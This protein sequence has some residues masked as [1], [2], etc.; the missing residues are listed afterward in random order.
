VSFLTPD[1]RHLD[2]LGTDR[3]AADL[4]GLAGQARFSRWD[5]RQAVP[6]LS[7]DE[8][9]DALAE[10]MLEHGDLGEALRDLM[11]RGWQSDDPSRG[12]LSG[13]RDLLDRLR[14]QR[15]SIRREGSL[16]DPLGDVRQA[17]EEIVSIER[18]GLERRLDEAVGDDAS[19]GAAMAEP[20]TDDAD[21]PT[22]DGSAA[23]PA[24]PA[25]RPT[26]SP[27]DAPES[28]ARLRRMLREIAARRM[29]QLDAMPP[30]VG[31][32]IRTL[33]DYDFL[34]PEARERFDALLDQL[35]QSVLDRMSEGLADAVK[36]MRPEDLAAQ[37][38]MVRDLN[39]LLE[40]R[41]AGEEPSQA[42]VDEFLRRHGG[43]FPGAETLDDVVEQLADRM[44]ALQSLL[45]SLSPEQRSEL[46]DTMDAL[47]RDDRLRWDLAQLAGNLDRLLPGGL[48]ERMQLTGEPPLGLEGALDQLG[49]LQALDA[50]EAS[51]EQL[52]DPGALADIDRSELRDLLGTDAVR[53]LDALESLARQLEQAGYLERRGERLELTPRGSRRIGQK[54]LDD[55]FGRLRRDAFGGHRIDRPGRGG[56]R[57]EVSK[58]YEHG[59]PFHL[60]LR[61][62]LD[63][64]LRR[65]ENAPNRRQG[66]VRLRPEDFEVHRTERLT[67]AAT[68]L[69]VDMSRSMLLRG[70]YIAAKR[71]AIALET[72]IRTQ[73]PRDHLA[74][75]GFAYYARELRPQALPELTWHGYEYGTNLQHGLLLARQIL[76]RQRVANREIVV[77][78]DG[79]PTAHF[80]DGQVEFSYPPT[81]RTV[82]ETLREVIRCTKEG[83]TINTFMLERSRALTDFVGLVTQLNRGRAFYAEPERLGEY[84]LVDFVSRRTGRSP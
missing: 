5:G 20:A 56:E 17:L 67:S 42:D 4:S 48:G 46:Q 72:L 40:Q 9:V 66:P 6:D 44:A 41:L 58:P 78:T 77:I 30:D 59:D 26:P 25:A 13:L 51:L 39:R 60:D 1:R 27:G 45:R 57:E 76:A 63:N 21:V 50:L 47:L 81:R 37:R 24:A 22:P 80:E 62:T 75:V 11:E 31:A 53:D 69:L 14:E 3:P 82:Q 43:Q 79:E 49:R 36:S 15:D 2:P 33:Q 55:L 52:G 16:A 18:A 83:I 74:I 19:A 34:E 70:C 54:V 64:A 71:V 10:G 68:V 38:E 35:R 28:D 12:D 29:D 84:V 65:D 7:A 61:A 8:I 23:P 32:R 73:Y